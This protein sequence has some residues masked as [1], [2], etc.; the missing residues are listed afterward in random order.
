[1]RYKT[2]L[3]II[4]G[5]LVPLTALS[6]RP[7]ADNI[8]FRA[9]Q[10]E[11][12]RSLDGLVLDGMLPPGFI[13]YHIVDA[14]TLRINSVL[15]GIVMSRQQ[16]IVRFDNRTLIL[17]KGITNENFLDLDNLGTWS[18]HDHN[19]PHTGT[20]EDMRRPLWLVTDERYKQALGTF[21]S[22][23]SAMRQQNLSREERELP[24]F[25][26]APRKETFIPRERMEIDKKRMEG[27]ATKISSVFTEFGRIHSSQ[28][29]IFIYDGQ[30]FYLNSEGTAAQ[31]P[32][33]LVAVVTTASAYE[34][35]GELLFEHSL[36]FAKNFSDIPPE[37]ALISEARKI[38]GYLEKLADI[39]P[40]TEPYFGPVL[41]EGQAV[42]EAFARVFF[43]GA[44]G[45]VA[46]RKPV[47]GDEQV[48]RFARD[49]IM[50][51]QLDLM[52]GRR[53]I[54][55]DLSIEAIPRQDTYRGEGLFGNFLVDAEGL[56]AAD[57]VS[58]VEDGV[59]K[60]LLTSRIPTVGVRESNSHARLALSRG[61]VTAITGP[62][63]VKM[64][65]DED[66]SL[67]TEQLRELLLRQADEEGLEYAYIVRKVVSPVARHGQED[68]LIFRRQTQQGRDLPKT[69][70]VYRI[71][72]DDGREEPVSMA[73]I[74]DLNIRSF[75]RILGASRDMQ[76]YNT[77]FAPATTPLFSGDFGLA[78]VPV[79]Y[80]VPQALLFEELDVVPEARQAIRKPPVVDNPVGIR[81]LD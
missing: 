15:G 29:N 21:E 70:Q 51:N 66:A 65:I 16:R 18:R 59:L 76:V 49:Y 13:S 69:I 41:F 73:E 42:A 79:S 64:K 7:G 20:V 31:Y 60:G 36:H 5:A 78:G 3:M 67:D 26:P 10:E 35:S 19:L 34:A 57:R 47:V 62:G 9:M 72:V 28:V 58:L 44:D 80:I 45:L 33:Q 24:D 75:R 81:G 8:Y 6:E 17:E 22:K 2:I 46:V 25:L 54:S 48:I 52:I 27:L 68:D 38:A 11:I 53:I 55:R 32:F 77:L 1:M 12:T 61:A 56:P 63:I 74:K 39:P 30:V 23:L 50:E 40:V 43:T 71:Y 37:E 4:L 14:N